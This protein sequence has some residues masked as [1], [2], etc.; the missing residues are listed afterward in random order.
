MTWRE[1][2]A[3]QARQNREAMAHVGPAAE[4]ESDLHDQILDECQRRGWYVVHARMDMRST[5]AVG[6][7]DFCVA[8]PNG[9]TVWVECKTRTGKLTKDQQAAHAWL[10]KLGHSVCVVRNIREFRD[11]AFCA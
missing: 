8:I 10:K 4:R 11:A 7:P 3:H 6:A 1:Y 2:Y 9:R 5:I